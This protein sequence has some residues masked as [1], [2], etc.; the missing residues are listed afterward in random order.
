VTAE[1][2]YELQKYF[3]K[4]ANILNKSIIEQWNHILLG[5]FI[6]QINQEEN[7][8]IQCFYQNKIGED[9]KDI[10]EV[11][12]NDDEGE[13]YFDDLVIL[14]N[15]FHDFCKNYCDNWKIMTFE[16]FND[17]NYSVNFG[18]DVDYNYGT[19]YLEKWKSKYFKY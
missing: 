8:S 6:Y 18:Y 2:K 12:W 4:I 15:D 14:L 17:G 10:Q 13:E 16:L 3:V 9:Y 1:N 11:F 7:K 19:V 5:M